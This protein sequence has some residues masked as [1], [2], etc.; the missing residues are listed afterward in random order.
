M[1]LLLLLAIHHLLHLA[2]QRWMNR[3]A[4]ASRRAPA[5]VER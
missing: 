4:R 5:G 1:F 3:R 2:F